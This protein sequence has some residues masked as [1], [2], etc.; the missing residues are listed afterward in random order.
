LFGVVTI[1][2]VRVSSEMNHRLQS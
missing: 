2:A 1:P